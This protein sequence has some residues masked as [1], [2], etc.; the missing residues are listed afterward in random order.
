MADMQAH[1]TIDFI[2]IDTGIEGATEDEN[3]KVTRR[4][5]DEIVKTMKDSN[6]PEDYKLRIGTR[7]GG[8]SGMQFL[9][10]FDNQ[11]ADV[12]KVYDVDGFDLVVDNKSIFYLMGITLDFVDGPQGSGFVFEGMHQGGHTCGCQG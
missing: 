6:V 5:I 11:Q 2:S 8:C 3:L 1:E 7:S 10:G 4:A 12:D 9:L